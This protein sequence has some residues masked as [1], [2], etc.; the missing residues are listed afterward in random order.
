MGPLNESINKGIL[1]VIATVL[2][3]TIGM[4]LIAIFLQDRMLYLFF[5]SV[6]VTIM[7][8]LKRAYKGDPTIFF[9]SASTMLL[10]F[11]N[12]EV[13][14]VFLYGVERTFMNI[15]AIAV[16]TLVGVFLWPIDIQDDSEECAAALSSTAV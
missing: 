5:V 7:L 4:T 16:Y 14:G 15:F 2:G 9:L 13:D 11:S 3:A 12:A 1:S 8:Y 10:V 6:I